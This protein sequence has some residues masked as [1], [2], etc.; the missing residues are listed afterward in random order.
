MISASTAAKVRAS[1]MASVDRTEA[2]TEPLGR[3]LGAERARAVAEL[4]HRGQQDAAGESVIQHV[5]RV[6]AR[7][8]EHARVV[9][10]LHEALE[11][12]PV[13]EETLLAEG[14]ST[15]E[16]RALRLLV[17]A[18]QARND[19]SYLAHVR[20][21]ARALGPG[22]ALARTVSGPISSTGSPIPRS[23]RTGGRLRTCSD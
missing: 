12:T 11:A 21:I 8:P 18:G 23:G 6:A 1:V 20:Q 19:V 17:R 22:A 16:L 3:S 4:L 10:W 14:L 7:V 5:G 2:G 15:G 9:A 13:P